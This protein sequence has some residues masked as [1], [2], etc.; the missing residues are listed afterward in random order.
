LS[1]RPL[2]IGTRGSDLALWQARH[3]AA[4]LA[5]LPGA[6]PT[7]LVLIR[8]EGD[9]VTDVPLAQVAGKAFFTKE[10]ED[11]LTAGTVDLAVHSQKDLATAMPAGLELGAVLEREDPRD[12]LLARAAD[13]LEALPEG[14]RVGTSSLRRRALLARWRPDLE[15]VDLRG[16]V[17]TR[18]ERLDEGRFNAIVLAAAG[19]RRLGM[20]ERISC[21]LPVEKMPPAVAQG[22]VAVQLRA[23]D[24]R[25]LTWVSRLDHAATRAATTAERALLAALEGG[26]QIPVGALARLDGERLSLAGTVCSLDG[27]RAV[28]D[29][30]EGAAADAA[31][32]GTE[33]ARRLVAAGAGEILAAIRAAS[34]ELR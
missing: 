29:R 27:R 26:C 12:A 22:A 30:I 18:I 5:R 16:N 2:R 25:T 11:A 19:V 14:A 3:V 1:E 13:S 4:L 28:E 21:Y 7:E 10:I 15:L 34:G 17:P 23:H 20:A 6:P 32:L 24:T 9:R 31:A 8:T 33:L